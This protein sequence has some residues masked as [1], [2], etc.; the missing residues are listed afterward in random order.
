MLFGQDVLQFRRMFYSA[1]AKFLNKQPLEPVEEQLVL[2]IQDHPEYQS[3]FDNEKALEA[4]YLPELGDSNPF[5]HMALHLSLREQVVTNRPDGI[6]AI[7][8]KLCERMKPIDAEHMMID[9]LAESLWMAQKHQ[10]LP[11]ET[12]YLANLTNLV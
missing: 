9:V 4:N 8:A 1:W 12:E 10:S 3:I 5:L 11:D 2:V 7:F 6:Q